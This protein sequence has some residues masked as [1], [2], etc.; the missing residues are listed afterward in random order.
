MLVKNHWWSSWTKGLWA[1]R[2]KSR[3][4]SGASAP[5]AETCQ[6]EVPP[7]LPTPD[8][9]GLVQSILAD[10]RH[11]LLLRRQVVARLSLEVYDQAYS[12]LE[13]TMAH[14]PAGEVE[15]DLSEL[16][17]AERPV[18]PRQQV[19]ALLLDR[20]PVTNA[21]F[22]RFV[23]GGG[24]KLQPLWD[25][26]IWPAVGGFVDLTGAPGPRFWRSGQYPGGEDDHPVIGVSWHEAAA[27]ARWTGKRLP[28]DAEWV[29]AAAWPIAL[30]D[31]RC[32]QRRF[33]WGDTMDRG[34]CNVWGSGPG[35][36]VSVRQ[37]SSGVSAGGVYQ[38]IGNVWEWTSSDF[39][40]VDYDGTVLEVP[41]PMKGIRGGAFDTYFDQQAT[42]Q[43]RS[44]ENRLARKHN[45]GFRCALS[46]CDVAPRPAGTTS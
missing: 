39:E 3:P 37:F 31:G 26:Q 29:R 27:Y 44:G 11:A 14:I 36:A 22:R 6:A 12:A 13:Q 10:Q 40:P 19:Q 20:C 34:R 5:A 25:A 1:R 38:L 2:S 23:A 24:Y 46:L 35:R 7:V 33:P 45:I 32:R 28:T 41:F 16:D 15:L 30:A 21:Q 17:P 43:F 4:G 8:T 18:A 42:C 9:A